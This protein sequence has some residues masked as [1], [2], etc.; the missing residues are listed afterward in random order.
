MASANSRSI[1]K[2]KAQA[3]RKLSPPV[4][5]AKPATVPKTYTVVAGDTLKRIASKSNT[6]IANIEKL[7]ELAPGAVLHVG[8][9]L[10]V[11]SMPKTA[12]TEAK[13]VVEKTTSAPSIVAKAPPVK[14]PEIASAKPQAKTEAAPEKATSTP[15]SYIVAKGDTPISIAKK[16]KV[17][18]ETLMKANN[19]DD[20][21]KLKI[22]QTIKVP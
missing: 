6:S 15:A 18:Q 5:A 7:N 2:R 19:I 14:A 1:R 21:R 20:P 13:P 8:Q 9:V 3:K 17:S 11:G 4:V 10:T 16:L 12:E 22:G